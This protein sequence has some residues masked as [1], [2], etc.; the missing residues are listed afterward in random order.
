MLP[1]HQPSFRGVSIPRHIRLAELLAALSLAKVDA[2]LLATVT[3]VG[4]S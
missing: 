1:R 3:R 4:S 2:N